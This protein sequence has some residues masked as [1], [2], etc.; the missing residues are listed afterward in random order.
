MREKKMLTDGEDR[1]QENKDT[2]KKEE[3]SDER[4]GLVGVNDS[5]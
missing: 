1:D 4:R 5:G 2:E 3:E